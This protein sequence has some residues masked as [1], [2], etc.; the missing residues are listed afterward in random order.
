[1]FK[2]RSV[3]ESSHIHVLFFLLRGRRRGDFLFLLGL[4][5]LLLLLLG[6]DLGGGRA[7]SRLDFLDL[8]SK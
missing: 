4:F 8:E 6:L 2:Y 7:S 5:L 1:M 3:E